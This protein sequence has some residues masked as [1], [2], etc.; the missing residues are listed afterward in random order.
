M[1]CGRILVVSPDASKSRSRSKWR[2]SSSGRSSNR[3][4]E[5][6]CHERMS[7]ERVSLLCKERVG[8]I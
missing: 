5:M 4:S 1:T 8:L 6:G 7:L 3:I 2:S